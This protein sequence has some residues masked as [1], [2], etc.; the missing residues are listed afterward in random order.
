MPRQARVKSE[1]GIYHLLLRGINK[2]NIF[3]DEEDKKRFLETLNYYKRISRYLLYGYCLMDNHIHLL[4]QERE[5][6]ISRII[7]RISSSYVHW[8]NQ[9]YMRCGHLFQERFKSEAVETEDYFLV[10]LRYIHQNPVKAGVTNA[11]NKYIWSSYHDYVENS[12]ITNIDLAL[13]IFLKDRTKAVELFINY[14]NESN[15]DQC[16][17]YLEKIVMSDQAVMNYLNEM[18]ITSISQLQQLNKELRNEVIR[19]IKTIEG[20]TIRQLARMTGIAKSV[21][22]R[23]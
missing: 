16:L 4:I 2:Q 9:K 22:N 14:H 23:V 8:Y 17:E 7:K 18:G 6:S 3:E 13:D 11:T 1:T 15:S 19:K 21:I 10:V 5:E 20:I 12:G